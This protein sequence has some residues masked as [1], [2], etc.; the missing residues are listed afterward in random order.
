MRIRSVHIENFKRFGALDIDLYPFDCLV[1]PNNSGKTTFLQAL[2]LFDFCVHH[3]L[4]RK[5]GNGKKE[6]DLEFKPR[7]ISPEE[8][9]VL[10]VASP[11]DLWTDRKTRSQN[12]H[13]VIKVNIAFD[14]GQSVSAAVFF[15]FNLFNVSVKST[16]ESQT[17]LEELRAFRISYL[18][19]FSM[20]LPQEPRSTRA[21]IED[22]LARGRVNSVIRNLLLDLKVEDRLEDLIEILQRIF[23]ALKNLKVHF[24]D[25]SDRYISVTYHESGRP[26]EFDIF[27]AG[28][29]FQQFIYLF[30][31]SLLRKPSVILLDE[32]DVHLHGTLQQVLLEALRELTQTGKQVLFATHSREMITQM[33]TR[34]I[35]YLEDSG[36]KRLEVAFDKYDTLDQL[37]SL[38]STQLP[39]IQAYRK[40]LILENESDK[41]L[42]FRFGSKILGTAIWSQV[43]RRLAV[44][45][46]RGNPYRQDMNRLRQQ[47]QEIVSLPGQTLEMFV[48]ADRD[49]HPDLTFLRDSLSQQH[50]QWH[51]WERAEIENYLLSEE[52]IIR[53]LGSDSQQLG[54]FESSVR[55]EFN[56]FIDSEENTDAV[57]DLLVKAFQEYARQASRGWDMP[58]ISREARTFLRERWNSEKLQLSDAKNIV[59]PGLKRWFQEHQLGQF[60]NKRLAEVLLP[61]DLPDEV[62]QL[63]GVLKVFAGIR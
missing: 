47:L 15:N 8:F 37:G 26:K 52:G 57:N 7:N 27:S 12:A 40:V 61:E 48:I 23:P 34:N 16:D 20:F 24:D 42:L 14:K 30:G 13:K 62:H 49:Y 38:E 4:N 10:P 25:V 2:A 3:C 22:A 18:P 41:E 43:T 44:C 53:L 35:L 46:S 33:N 1:G 9:Y 11:V 32:P 6:G 19:V 31:F 54:L 5:N 45:Y 36:P 58:R 55:E 28:S 29:G 56:R 59:L 63:V 21:V 17:F 50:I 39:I 60:S 51:V